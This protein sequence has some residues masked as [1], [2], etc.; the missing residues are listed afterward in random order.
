MRWWRARALRLSSSKMPGFDRIGDDEV[1]VRKN[2]VAVVSASCLGFIGILLGAS[3]VVTFPTLMRQ[4]AVPLA[5]VQWL[6]AGYYL[7]ATITMSTTAYLMK[8]MALR[9]LF[10]MAGVLFIPGC[11]LSAVAPSFSVLLVG[12]LL[13][14]VATGLAT[15]LM[16]QVVFAVIPQTEFGKYNGIV[17]MI[18]S[19]GPAFGPAYG[20]LLAYWLSWRVLFLGVLPLLALALVA[21]M[22]TFPATRPVVKETAK[23]NWGGLLFFGGLLVTVSLAINQ[24]G[25]HYHHLTIAGMFLL[26]AVVC[27]GLLTVNLRHSSRHYLNF[28]LLKRPVVALRAACFFGLQF[29]NLS[30]VFVVP[31]YAEVVLHY[32]SLVAGFLL[33]PGAVLGALLSPLAGRLYDVRGGFFT[34]ML[35][36]VLL[37]SG[38][39]LYCGLFRWL[40]VGLIIGIYVIFRLGYTFGFGNI[41]TDAGKYV[42]QTERGGV[43][44]LFNVFQQYA[45]TIGTNVAA[46]I[47]AALEA[48]GVTSTVALLRGGQW[49]LLLLVVMT[50]VIMLL[51]GI[52]RRFT[53]AAA[54]RE[55]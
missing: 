42:P 36:S 34:L 29:V 19:F 6:S 5:V 8:R 28:G 53:K 11:L 1:S 43:S 52:S 37:F 38:T 47:E 33:L 25:A 50:A 7:A 17:T 15:P 41:I 46:S 10:L 18:K 55:E 9:R 27:G 14:A 13:C 16:Y 26:A 21:G 22:R 32:N 31:L 23:F 2:G 35:A 3:L 20:G 54:N 45:G 30:L 49:D 12:G 4:F 51:V 48:C 40:N 24:V 39:V 44:S